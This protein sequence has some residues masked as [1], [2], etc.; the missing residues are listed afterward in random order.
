[1]KKISNNIVNVFLITLCTIT[2]I[3]SITQLS[4]L[5]DILSIKLNIVYTL[6]VVLCV[7]GYIFRRRIK[8]GIKWIFHHS[9]CYLTVFLLVVCALVIYQLNLIQALTGSMDL[10]PAFIYNLILHKPTV[11]SFYFSWYPNLLFLLNVENG[12]YNLLGK[13]SLYVFLT[14]LSYINM[15]LIDSGLILLYFAVKKQSNK[16]Y[17][18]LTFLIGVVLYGITPYIVIPYSDNWAFWVCSLYLF[19]LSTIFSSNHKFNSNKVVLLVCLGVVNALLFQIKPSTA[20]ALIATIIICLVIIIPRIKFSECDINRFI[21]KLVKVTLVLI[22]PFCLTYGIC[23]YFA[24]NN[25]LVK[26][27]KGQAASPLHFMAMGLHGD[28]QYWEEFN[29]KDQALSPAKRKEYELK[30]IKKDITDFDSVADFSNFVINKQ[31]HNSSLA[32]WQR[33]TGPVSWTLSPKLKLHNKFQKKL[34][35]IF[36]EQNFFQWNGYLIFSQLVW[37]ISIIGMIL[38]YSS[39]NYYVQI[40][41]Y[42]VVG[43]FLFLILF[44]GG[45]SRYMIQYLPF[46]LVLSSYGFFNIINKSTQMKNIES[47]GEKDD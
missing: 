16:K 30:T 32:S 34:R 29:N 4:I 44:E 22:I 25:G 47:K 5:Q 43:G 31:Q 6:L 35:Y 14:S 11:G 24:N 9:Y 41:K 15:F 38:S 8:S 20:I 3:G 40:I 39:K 7:C 46:M 1:M 36:T 10:D 2:L 45:V 19:L 42:T 27:E 23:N 37:V 12:I 21:K 18:F 28:G 33:N 13:P 17:A 26:I